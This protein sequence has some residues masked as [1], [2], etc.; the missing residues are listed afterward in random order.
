MLVDKL[1]IDLF[2]PAGGMHILDVDE[3]LLVLYLYMGPLLHF[4]EAVV[5]GNV[6]VKFASNQVLVIIRLR[7]IPISNISRL[8]IPRKPFLCYV[9]LC[10]YEFFHVLV[11]LFLP[12]YNLLSTAHPSIRIVYLIVISFRN[13]SGRITM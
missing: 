8:Y 12:S 9:P 11:T 6:N 4:S 13:S 5:R 10:M 1:H 3:D 2:A 7:A